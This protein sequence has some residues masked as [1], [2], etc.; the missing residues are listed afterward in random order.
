MS[1]E[2]PSYTLDEARALLPE[3]RATLLQL[4]LG[5][6][7]YAEAHAT[8]HDRSAEDGDV[9]EGVASRSTQA[10]L[11]AVRD[12]MH[13]LMEHLEARGV[14]VRDL[15]EGLVDI[16]TTRDGEPAWF[17]WRLADPQ[18]AFWHTTR[19]GYSSRRPL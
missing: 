15:D 14:Q 6:R 10:E 17:C 18:L 9:E 2:R 4:A 19:E 11:A 12:D 1:Q 3:I 7:R 16:P 8:L 13:A 5:R